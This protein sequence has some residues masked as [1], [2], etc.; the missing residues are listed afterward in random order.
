MGNIDTLGNS[1][2]I[3]VIL[4]IDYYDSKITI[5]GYFKKAYSTVFN[6]VAQWSFNNWEPMTTG[7]WVGDGTVDDSAGG[8]RTFKQ[9]LNYLY[10]GGATNGAG[11][12]INQSSHSAYN[13]AKWNN[14][15]WFPLSPP[16]QPCGVNNTCTSLE[17]Y[18][19]N[20]YLGGWFNLSEDTAGLHTTPQIARWNDTVFSP[21]GLFSGDFSGAGLMCLHLYQNRLVAGGFFSAIDGSPYGTYSG[22]AAYNDTIWN[23]L[24]NGFNNAVYALT[25]YN[26]TLYAG[27]IFT[28]SRDGTTPLNHIAK[29]TGTTWQQVGEGLND[30]VYTLTVDSVNNKLYAGGGFTQT[31]LGV[32]AKHLAEWTGTNWQEVGG[33]TNR[34]VRAL[35]AKDGNLYVGGTFTKVG[36]TQANLIACWGSNPAYV[37]EINNQINNVVIYPNPSST[38]FTIHSEGMKIKQIKIFNVIGEQIKTITNTETID[39]TDLPNGIYFAEIKSEKAIIRKKIIK[40]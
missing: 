8:A 3:R 32:T 40:Q 10:V 17:V 1:N 7:L 18:K 37:N 14:I 36:G 20:L 39:I 27:G 2:S 24:G 16:T 30:T 22:I 19:N 15:D 25:V 38:L 23:T 28:T 5:G 26:D 9:Y 33:G 34:A 21:A 6:S 29:W 35:F 11:G 31:G 4:D 13:I 12:I